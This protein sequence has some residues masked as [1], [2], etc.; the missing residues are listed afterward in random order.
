MTPLTMAPH[1]W[2]RRALATSRRRAWAAALLIA[3]AT[4]VVYGGT[5][6]HGFH[7]DDFHSIVRNPAI[8]SLANVGDY[9]LDPGLFSV[10]A[11]S[12]MFRPLLLVSY[13]LN[14]AVS[15]DGPAG[16]HAVNVLWHAA[17]AVLVLALLLQL[18]EGLQRAALAGALFALS[19]VNAEAAA[20]VSSRSEL[21]T[22]LCFLGSCLAYG[23]W[24]ARR[25]GGWYVLSLAL[26][27]GAL[28]T[29]SVAAVLPA[30][31]VLL[32]WRRG[33]GALVR[34][35][36]RAYAPF[37]VLVAGYL[38]ASRAVVAKA[39]LQPVRPWD[40]QVWTQLKAAVYYAKLW[41]MPVNLSV[42]HQF[43]VSGSPGDAPV[44]AAMALV[45]SVAALLIRASGMGA[46]VRSG[47]A[48]FALGLSPSAVVPLIVL[49]NEH[50]LYLPG[51]GLSMAAAGLL[52]AAARRGG[53]VA[54]AGIAVYA[55]LFAVLTFERTR[56]WADELSLWADAADKAPLMVKP[57]VRLADALAAAG[58]LDQAEAA[59]LRALG[60]RPRHVA[61]RNNLGLLYM[62]RGQLAQ[63]ADQFRHLL[64]TYPD[65]APA[66]LNLA[67]VLLRRGDWKAARDEYERVLA[68]QRSA[69][70]HRHLGHIALRF[71]GDAA[72]ALEHYD[73]ALEAGEGHAPR[74]RVARGV[75]LRALG[76]PGEA[77]AAYRQALAGDPSLLEAWYNLG[78]L[79]L[80]QDRVA[81][82]ADAFGRAV[83]LEPDGPLAER[84]RAI[85]ESIVP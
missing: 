3:A 60:L 80:E 24:H 55:T 9:F 25:A 29:K 66:R 22:A 23:R 7:Y 75:A 82:A 43:E 2:F 21:L 74:V 37:A 4:V 13:A 11:E 52:A 33:G 45:L 68:A 36:W 15:G 51:V 49:V 73:R 16:Y 17:N 40:V 34:G 35:R 8:R 76:R 70:A 59:Y 1:G 56:A 14:H 81:E 72:R 62:E 46:T 30:A 39:M 64:E 31:L 57:H 69:D 38:A 83:E 47:A 58:R 54:A 63:A 12:A 84:A 65:N 28:L 79:L 48:W 61:A 44:L 42:E 85:L 10:N 41:V 67:G 26:G 20:Y 27:A 5:V 78:N 71:G 50:R 53:A 32:D 19:P 18:G 6:S 77:E